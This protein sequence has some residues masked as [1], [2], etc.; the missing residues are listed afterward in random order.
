MAP[1]SDNLAGVHHEIAAETGTPLL[2]LAGP[3]TGKTFAMMRRVARLL[4]ESVEPERILTLSFTR[5][6]ATD[7]RIQLGNLGVP[8]VVVLE[9]VALLAGWIPALRAVAV[10]PTEALRAE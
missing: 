9:A 8:G 6:A 3:G 7:L 2:V 4:E 1:W 10:S 5:T